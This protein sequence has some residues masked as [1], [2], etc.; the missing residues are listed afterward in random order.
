MILFQATVDGRPIIKKNTA[1]HYRGRVVYSPKYVQWSWKA[2][3]E[4]QRVRRA[5]ELKTIDYYIAADVVF[6]LKNHQSEPDCSNL[7]EG[8]QD[9][10]TKSFVIKD[11][12]F[13]QVLHVRKVFGEEP[14]TEIT[15]R[16][17]K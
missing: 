16:T 12:K 7:V 17:L 8:S 6:Y 10:L 2:I 9:C 5:T 3:A 11:D 1:R 14:R 13:I 4:F 15:L